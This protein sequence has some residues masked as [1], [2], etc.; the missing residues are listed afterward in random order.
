VSD[1]PDTHGGAHD[2]GVQRD[3]RGRPLIV[4]EG[5][6]KPIAY[7]RCSTFAKTLSDSSGLMAWKVRQVVKGLAMDPTLLNHLRTQ[8]LAPGDWGNAA[9][10]LVADRAF[11]VAGAGESAVTGTTIHGL[12]EW[13]D[14]G[15]DIDWSVPD[16]LPFREFV[17][18]Y[19]RLTAGIRMIDMEQFVVHDQLQVAGTYDRLCGLPAPYDCV[20]IGD[21]KTGKH[22]KRSPHEPAIQMGTYAESRRYD[23]AT[24]QR[25]P[26]HPDL[27]PDVGVLIHVPSNGEP[28]GV[29]ILDLGKA[30]RVGVQL[31]HLTKA[32]RRAKILTPFEPSGVDMHHDHDNEGGTTGE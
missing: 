19:R 27:N 26:I 24:W 6:G 12:T 17:L 20:A 23:P 30:R 28:S 21:I 2:E 9:L 29:Y 10:D 3:G 22:A 14:A 32:W 25:S 16:F 4:P 15:D 31:A 1:D 18:E 11:D 5:G 13:L 8:R 7:Q